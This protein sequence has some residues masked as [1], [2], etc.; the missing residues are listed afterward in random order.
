MS[1]DGKNKTEA[2]RQRAQ[3]L[4]NESPETFKASELKD[5]RTSWRC[6]RLS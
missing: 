4:L 2:L 3:K 5:W 6:I 1:M